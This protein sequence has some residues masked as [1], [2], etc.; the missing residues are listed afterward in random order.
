ME[1]VSAILAIG[2]LLGFIVAYCWCV[3]WVISD[4]TKRGRGGVGLFVLFWLFGP[5][6]A[7]VWLMIRPQS[8]LLET[9]IEDFDSPDE[10]IA[11]GSKLDAIGEW[12]AA[13]HAFN[14]VAQKWPEH[15]DY[16]R[17]CISSIE[18]KRSAVD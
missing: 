6:S 1:I 10:A 3:A 4:A 14:A 11:A 13:I 16:A 12:D 9:R 18:K 2:V 5:L 15:A 8:T 17:N 7:L